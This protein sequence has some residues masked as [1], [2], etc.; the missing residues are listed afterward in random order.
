MGFIILSSFL[1]SL[2]SSSFK[3]SGNLVGGA[4]NFH[5]GI[6]RKLVIVIETQIINR[7]VTSVNTART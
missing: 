2:S 1:S 5:K 6:S 7:N 4:S 3:K